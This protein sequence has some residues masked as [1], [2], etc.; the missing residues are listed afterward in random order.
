LRGLEQGFFVGTPEA[1]ANSGKMYEKAVALDPG[2]ADAYA[3]LGGLRWLEYVW[4]SDNDPHALD[5]A[6]ELACKAIS[7]DD[8]NSGAYTVLGW[9]VAYRG[10]PNEAIAD[11]KRAIALDPNYAIAYIALSEI[12]NIIGKPEESLTYA[13][14]ALRLDPNQGGGYLSQGSAYNAMG[15]YRE[16][17]DALR[18]G[19]ANNLQ[20]SNPYLHLEL[21]YTYSEL[22][23]EQDA[24]A[25]AAEVLRLSPQFSMEVVMKRIP[26]NCDTPYQRHFL[27]D[28]R[29][30]GLK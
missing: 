27:H 10:R 15:R 22:G 13:Q 25:E 4:Q 12:L 29:R 19:Q 28:L 7:L 8:S 30:A 17:L 24:R 18:A 6:E 16:A 20:A 9:V 5:R 2:Y 11:E 14:K 1:I 26:G 23:R 21:I 3:V